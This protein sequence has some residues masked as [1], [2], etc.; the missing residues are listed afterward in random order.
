M[1]TE[2]KKISRWKLHSVKI[3]EN[4]T[5]GYE[6]NTMHAQMGCSG[7]CSVR[8]HYASGY[9]TRHANIFQWHS[10]QTC[11]GLYI[12]WCQICSLFFHLFIH[13][14]P[15]SLILEICP[16]LTPFWSSK[17]ELRCL[18]LGFFTNTFSHEAW[19]SFNMLFPALI[20]LIEKDTRRK[21]EPGVGWFI[22]FAL[23]PL[24]A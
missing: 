23:I 11:L 14:I 12:Y 17:V 9:I 5:A 13:F 21:G 8:E 2:W 1:Y 4:S 18:P 3:C 19:S 16:S 6:V 7:L 10:P 22:V 15:H 20:T 24:T